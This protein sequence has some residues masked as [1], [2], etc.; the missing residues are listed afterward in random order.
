MPQDVLWVVLSQPHT[1][2]APPV[3]PCV[4]RGDVAAV[5][6]G[7]LLARMDLEER[8]TWWTGFGNPGGTWRSEDARGQVALIWTC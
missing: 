3:M 7:W 8:I 2:H 6:A 1:T 4:F 5:F